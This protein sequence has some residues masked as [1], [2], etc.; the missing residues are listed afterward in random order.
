MPAGFAGG[1][2]GGDGRAQVIF[3]ATHD[4]FSDRHPF[5]PQANDQ[6]RGL[7]ACIDLVIDVSAEGNVGFVDLERFSL[8]ETLRHVGRPED[9]DRVAKVVGLAVADA[10]PVMGAVLRRLF[11]TSP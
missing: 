11:A 1:Q 9:A 5:L 4:E 6:D 7:G 3:C 10:L 2:H 8:E